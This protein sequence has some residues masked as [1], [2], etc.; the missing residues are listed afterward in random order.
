MRLT[1]VE[2]QFL[3]DIPSESAYW[4]QENDELF[5]TQN[6]FEFLRNIESDRAVVFAE[7]EAD[8]QACLEL[9]KDDSFQKISFG[10]VHQD[11]KERFRKEIS[12]GMNPIGQNFT[13]EKALEF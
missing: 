10:I 3:E 13:K 9:I 2:N 5:I 1:L 7:N 12:T 6:K 8:F 4:N 11:M